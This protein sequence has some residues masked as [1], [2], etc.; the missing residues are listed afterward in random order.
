MKSIVIYCKSYIRD[1]ERA[2]SLAESVAKYNVENIPLY[3]SVPSSD[4]SIFN[5]R[6]K[7]LAII[8]RDE[9]IHNVNVNENGWVNQQIIKSS[10]WKTGI[11]ENYLMIDSDSYFIRPFYVNDFIVDG[12]DNIPYTVMHEQKDLFSWTANKKKILGFDPIESFKDC[13]SNIMSLF[14]RKGRFY[15][16]G[17][18]PVVWNSKVWKSLEENYLNPSNIT[19]SQAITS[20]KSEFAWYGEWL[21]TDKTIPIYPIEPLFKVFHY[22]PQYID[23]KN[24]NYTEQDFSKNYMG[25]V[26][27]SNW[28]APLKY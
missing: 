25:I 20:I 26:M 16:F 12:S 27:Q 9:D 19:F 14:D 6:L 18:S 23:F 7:G 17:P 1:L 4:F 21:L 8:I 15:D 13:R 11:C 22:M 28:G 24:Q 3:I 10:F 5:D 2:T